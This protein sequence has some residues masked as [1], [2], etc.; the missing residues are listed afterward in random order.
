MGQ[1]YRRSTTF[2]EATEALSDAPSRRLL[3]ALATHSARSQEP[4]TPSGLL[5]AKPDS[6]LIEFQRVHLPKLAG[7]GYV[8]WD[9]ERNELGIGPAF[10]DL[11]PLLVLIREHEGEL[12]EELV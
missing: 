3:L 1:T 11:R 12:P 7:Y 2:E 6:S 8:N 10:E 9:P 5:P 4:V